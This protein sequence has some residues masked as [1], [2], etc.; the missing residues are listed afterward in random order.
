MKGKYAKKKNNA[1][2]WILLMC[3]LLVFGMAALWIA[4][5]RMKRQDPPDPET[6]Q[7]AMQETA[8]P[9]ETTASV[10]TTEP[11]TSAPAEF[12][13]PEEPFQPINL[14][15]GVT[16]E[17]VSQYTGIYMEDGSDEL[18][19]GVMMIGVRN[20]GLND[21]QLMNITVSFGEE[22]YHFKLTNMPAGA[23]AVLLELDRGQMPEGTPVSAIAEDVVLFDEPMKA[24]FDSYEIS[25]MSG[26]MNVKNIS[27]HDISG[28]IYV[29]YKYKT[30]DVY[31]G[32]IT[33]R[34]SIQG[35]LKAGEIRQIMTSHF[36]PDTCE[37]LVIEEIQTN[38]NKD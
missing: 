31:Y 38:G 3:L 4:S 16:L 8:V 17:T 19:A 1:S 5:K 20:A 11:E 14:G 18:V 2:R 22:S 25:G 34:I 21:I 36:N 37:V 10:E 32:G 7:A 27:D 28:D 6:T 13:S 9:P 30:Q 15:Y 33:F 24:D 26:A 23:S 35:G 12:T 29:Y